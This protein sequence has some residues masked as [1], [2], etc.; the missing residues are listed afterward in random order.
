MRKPRAVVMG[1]NAHPFLMAYWLYLFNTYWRDE[2][3]K[4]YICISNPI[5]PMSWGYTKAI[6]EN[7][8]KIKVIETNGPWPRSVEL[9]IEQVTEDSILINHDDLFVMKTG[10]IDEM[11]NIVENEGKCVTPIHGNYTPTD[12]IRELMT[13]KWGNKLPFVD[14]RT[15]NTEYS[16]Y[17]NFFFAPTELV[18]RSGFNLGEYLVKKDGYCKYL[19]WTFSSTEL[20]ADTNFLFGLQLLEAGAE[21][22]IIPEYDFKAFV[23]LNFNVIKSMKDN[24]EVLTDLPYLHFQTFSY[25][26]GGLMFDFGVRELLETTTGGKVLPLIHNTPPPTE[27]VG[28]NDILMKVATLLEMQKTFD[29]SGMQ[30]WVNHANEQLEYC[31]KYAGI[32][33]KELKRV[34]RLI[35]KILKI[36]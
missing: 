27:I 35:G 8:P 9:G 30:K 22:K 3:D 1:T 15:N 25:H 11:F 17:C 18:K 24:L 32:T 14:P 23:P 34:R 10:V 5:Y 26:I 31:R 19:N 28:H 13:K 2:V 29:F 12:L 4:V 33:N 16:F 21:F 36:K 20:H 6:L 7:N